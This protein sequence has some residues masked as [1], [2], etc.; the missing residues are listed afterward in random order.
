MG[1]GPCETARRASPTATGCSLE[2]DGDPGL[3]GRYNCTDR[4]PWIVEASCKNRHKQFVLD[5]RKRFARH[6]DQRG[7]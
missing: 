3:Q 1:Q 4:Y 5:Q 2:R 7:R 6:A